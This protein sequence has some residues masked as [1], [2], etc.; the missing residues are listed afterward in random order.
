MYGAEF[1]SK[2]INS[3]QSKITSLVLDLF[4]YPYLI[5]QIPI[6]FASFLSSASEKSCLFSRII[7][8]ALDSASSRRSESFIIFH[9][10]VEKAHS[11]PEINPL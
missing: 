8:S 6:I 9:F 3:S 11:F 2:V 1:P 4:K 10:L 5:A 7:F